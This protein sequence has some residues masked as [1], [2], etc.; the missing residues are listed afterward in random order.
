MI[1]KKNGKIALL[2]MALVM[3]LGLCACGD[4]D[5]GQGG[6]GKNKEIN[7]P[8]GMAEVYQVAL[9]V[10]SPNVNHIHYVRYPYYY[11]SFS[12]SNSYGDLDLDYDTEHF[13][14]QEDLDFFLDFIEKYDN[15]AERTDD[16][17]F[18]YCLKVSYYPEDDDSHY[19]TLEVAYGYD[20]FPEELNEV[21]DR[22]N[23]L[24]GDDLLEYPTEMIEDVPSFI[25]EETKVSEDD[26]PREDIENMLEERGLF[27]LDDM[28]TSAGGFA[29]L[30]GSYYS[31]VAAKNIEDI[32]SR[33]L[34][35]ATEIS[36]DE[37]TEFVEKY[38]G[39]LSGDWEMTHGLSLDGLTMIHKD[40]HPTHGYMYIGKAE[41]VSEWEKNGDLA[42]DEN[43]N[44][45]IYMMPDGEEG[46]TKGCK[47]VYNK[48]ASVI[49]VDY[50]CA[51]LD[52]DEY[53]E[54][55]Y[56]FR[57]KMD[58]IEDKTTEEG[59]EEATEEGTEERTE[60]GSADYVDIPDEL[61]SMQEV[62]EYNT[63][64]S[65]TVSTP[66][67]LSDSLEDMSF[68]FDGEI[69]Q[70]PFGIS[71][72]SSDWE[73]KT[74]LL[75]F[76]KE[77]DPD[78]KQEE[79]YKNDNYDDRWGMV[80]IKTENQTDSVIAYE[81]STVCGFI[82]SI[83]TGKADEYPELILPKG[84]TWGSSVQDIYDAYG[85]PAKISAL[86]DEEGT[87]YMV[88]VHYYPDD[89]KSKLYRF[90]IDMEDGLYNVSISNDN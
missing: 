82:C 28:F 43:G 68:M 12:E 55:F 74:E 63:A 48:D 23:N 70:M 20:S 75:E 80:S 90:E 50:D 10:A 3:L 39:Q 89:E 65:K 67:G 78:K 84:I 25:Y 86:T 59:T 40:G 34:L 66:S 73:I 14:P 6:K 9:T 46:M 42:Y 22:L 19:S 76:E 24:C 38:I 77:I 47:F 52:Y 45:C 4:S 71:S 56:D 37:Y 44:K 85:E 30:M 64:K 26:Y 79:L 41:I 54:L 87:L 5:G 17:V 11:A 18:T 29:G 27:A 49:L 60:E 72:L 33:G 16:S 2:F 83:F 61:S 36:D 31:S 58:E 15:S 57:D 51:G 81:D 7:T 1:Y 21:I 62:L 32:T 35:D 13:I 88:V 69:Y 53:V 8:E